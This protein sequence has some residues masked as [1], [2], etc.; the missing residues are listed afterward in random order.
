MLN[1]LGAHI[2]PRSWGDRLANKWNFAIPGLPESVEV[3]A[4]RLGQTGEHT[5]MAQAIHHPPGPQ[6]VTG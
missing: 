6:T 1:R 5:A 2:E 3:H 4:Q